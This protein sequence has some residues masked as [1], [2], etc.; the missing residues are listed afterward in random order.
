[1]K[2]STDQRALRGA[3]GVAVL[4]VA[5]CA[6]ST[7]VVEAPMMDANASASALAL[8]GRAAPASKN[9][10]ASDVPF[11]LGDRWS[12]TYT[13]RQGQTEMAIVFEDIARGDDGSVQVEA[14]FEFRF[15]GSATYAASE[16]AARMSGKYEPA[17]KRLRLVGEEWLEQPPGYALVNLVGTFGVRGTGSRALTYSGTVEGPGCT[18]F[19][20]KPD[21]VFDMPDEQTGKAGSRPRSLPR[22]RP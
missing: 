16:G 9:E 20:A 2:R 22:P 7:G 17:S 6:R 14:T 12:G 19:S 5:A 10:D 18:S 13:C 15:A 21:D 1:M 11:H 4:A 3:L 8:A